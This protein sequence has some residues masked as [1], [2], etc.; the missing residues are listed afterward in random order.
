MNLALVIQRMRQAGASPEVIVIAVEAIE[1]AKAGFDA[2]RANDRERKAR[3]RSHVTSRDS[4]VTSHVTLQ[5][6]IERKRHS[7]SRDSH[8]TSPPRDNKTQ[9]P[10]DTPLG[11]DAPTLPKGSDGDPRKLGKRL[12]EDWTPSNADCDFAYELGL[13]GQGLDEAAAEFRD[14]WRGVP[15][16]RGRKLDWDATFRNRLRETAGK[17]QGTAHGKGSIVEA[18]RRLTQRLVAAEREREVQAERGFREGD[19]ALRVIPAQRR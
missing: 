4:H 11:A 12:P 1:E 16:Q 19:D 5:Q 6:P 7:W 17:K 13:G 9:P 14:Y 18:G 15:G 10:H 3:Q 8:G 2:R